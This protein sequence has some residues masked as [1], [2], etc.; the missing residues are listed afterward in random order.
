MRQ[1]I[2]CSFLCTE[3]VMSSPKNRGWK[4]IVATQHDRKIN[5]RV[6][7]SPSNEWIIMCFTNRH[8]SHRDV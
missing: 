7:N 2:M 3:V 5:E 6:F 1:N 8:D 4:I